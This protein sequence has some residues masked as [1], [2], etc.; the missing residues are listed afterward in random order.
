M[1]G[2]GVCLLIAI[3]AMLFLPSF[4]S[5]DV[6]N[7]P[8][9]A[10][11]TSIIIGGKDSCLVN[12]PTKTTET[13]LAILVPLITAVGSKAIDIGFD[14]LTDYLNETL[15]NEASSISVS[16]RSI[17]F[18]R[19][20]K[21][22]EGT[23][24]TEPALDCMVI[25]RGHLGPVD[26][27]VLKVSAS[28]QDPKG[29]FGK[30][31]E[32]GVWSFPVLQRLGFSDFPDVYLEFVFERDP[33]DTVF[34]LQPR[35]AYLKRTAVKPTADGKIDLNLTL[36]ISQPGNTSPSVILPFRLAGVQAGSDIP[37]EAMSLDNPW[38][39]MLAPPDA[40]FTQG[41]RA[42]MFSNIPATPANVM[43]TLEETGSQS[44]FLSFLA[45]LMSKSKGDIS[46]A[47]TD[48][49]R[50]QANRLGGTLK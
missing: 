40:T 19:V 17:Y 43:I 50:E 13:A 34:R 22:P 21:S 37:L 44:K 26:V 41:E 8:P 35:V 42:K 16:M 32:T 45:R 12:P 31:S 3:D 10:Q 24:G 49:L 1:R 47:A 5:A 25:A 29:R 9:N 15:K 7:S 48:L 2:I 20:K 46:S 39:P 28:K 11:V 6:T 18:Y 27:S 14:A 36:A 23:W 4:A 33:M 38:A 30:V